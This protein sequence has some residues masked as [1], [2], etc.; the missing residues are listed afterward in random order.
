MDKSLKTIDNLVSQ[1]DNSKQIVAEQV[2]TQKGPVPLIEDESKGS[3]E[4]KANVS[5][6]S[7]SS[8][9]ILSKKAKK[10]TSKTEGKGVLSSENIPNA[11]NKPGKSIEK[12]EQRE[13]LKE[14]IKITEP[15]DISSEKEIIDTS[16]STVDS[17]KSMKHSDASSIKTVIR[18]KKVE[19]KNT[20]KKE[21]T[22]V[23]ESETNTSSFKPRKTKEIK[24]KEK[25]PT[26]I[27]SKPKIVEPQPDS[28]SEME[29]ETEVT[30]TEY[31]ATED[32][33]ESLAEHEISITPR[34]SLTGPLLKPTKS[35][36]KD[37][38]PLIKHAQEFKKVLAASQSN[39]LSN[40]A[41]FLSIF[42]FLCRSMS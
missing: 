6:S 35:H 38:V 40:Y 22:S 20:I 33:V 36:A 19:K 9:V 27:R 21:E 4:A 18:H 31:S 15:I 39:A 10:K 7:S 2:S 16:Q 29:V 41:N 26:K 37:K 1:K 34:P 11:E 32:D 13:T 42:P 8:R 25:E 14:S 3:D 23:S 28:E 12:I 17:K 24:P 30:G 5:I